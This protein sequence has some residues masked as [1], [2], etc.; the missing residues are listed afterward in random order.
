MD[1]FRG[2]SCGSFQL[3]VLAKSQFDDGQIH[4]AARDR[5]NVYDGNQIVIINRHFTLG[6]YLYKLHL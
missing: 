6:I 1:D 4:Q 2:R 3:L 5:V